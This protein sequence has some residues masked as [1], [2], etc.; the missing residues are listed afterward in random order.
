MVEKY[1][2]KE[3]IFKYT[4]ESDYPF[5][6]FVLSGNYPIVHC[7]DYWEF[8]FCFSD[9]T[10][11]INGE[12]INIVGPNIL[13]VRPNDEH[14]FENCTNNIGQANFK[15]TDEAFRKFFDLFGME[16]YNKIIKEPYIVIPV[17]NDSKT[18]F[19]KQITEI[20]SVKK[21]SSLKIMLLV[22]E[23]LNYY[24]NHKNFSLVEDSYDNNY[25]E[26]ILLDLFSRLV[27]PQNFS[28]KIRDIVSGCGYSY[29]Q[30]HRLFKEHFGCS[31]CDFFIDNK[32]KYA[33]FLLLQTDKKII[34]ISNDVGYSTPYAFCRS[35]EKTQGISP[36]EYRERKKI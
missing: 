35:F 16:E 12:R 23:F 10:E 11:I 5:V 28:E 6:S 34:E 15:M 22:A 2:A 25:Q 14:A 21:N 19:L 20:V 31:M 13:I 1:L 32:I 3:H 9:V 27:S 8:I 24:L 26:V 17:D 30:C 18:K 4:Q 33:K 29:M 7:H 36:S